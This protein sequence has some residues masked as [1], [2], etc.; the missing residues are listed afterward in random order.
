[1]QLKNLVNVKN[2]TNDI[3]NIFQNMTLSKSI[4]LNAETLQKLQETNQLLPRQ[5]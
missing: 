1:M 3:K 2:A 4:N 5:P